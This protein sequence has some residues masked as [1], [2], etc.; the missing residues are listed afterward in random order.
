MLEALARQFG[1]GPDPGRGVDEDREYGAIAEADLCRD[2]DRGEEPCDLVRP[3]FWRLP[4]DNRITLGPDGGGRVDDDHVPVE[5]PVEKL[6]LCR[7]M[8]LLGRMA[9]GSS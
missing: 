8:E 4:F 1:D 6:A 7:Q 3:E 5:Q 9:N 2:F